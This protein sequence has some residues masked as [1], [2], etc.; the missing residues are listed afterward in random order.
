MYRFA[1]RRRRRN[2]TGACFSRFRAG[3]GMRG[4]G[5]LLALAL[6]VPLFLTLPGL[7]LAADEATMDQ[8]AIDLGLQTGAGPLERA[9]R[10]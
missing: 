9:L 4:A 7:A 10:A 2:F 6:A 8:L 5:C 3:G 1:V